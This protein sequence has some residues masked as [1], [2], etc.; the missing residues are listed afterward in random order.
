[1]SLA[2][3]RASGALRREACSA[4]RKRGLTRSEAYR[5]LTVHSEIA[6]R[7]QPDL[8]ARVEMESREGKI[9][10]S[11]LHA[12]VLA[13]I[14]KLWDVVLT[15]HDVNPDDHPQARSAWA[16]LPKTKPATTHSRTLKAEA[17]RLRLAGL[18]AARKR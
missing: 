10:S 1:M 6:L 11:A 13:A 15:H 3:R 14:S 16:K 18:E 4:Y 12:Q 7:D 2:E 5:Y 17:L 8:R 9:L